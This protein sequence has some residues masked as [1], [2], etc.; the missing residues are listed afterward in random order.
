LENPI[1]VVFMGLFMTAW[2][3]L[4]LR[5]KEDHGSNAKHEVASKKFRS[6]VLKM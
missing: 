6:E 3:H 1:A 2:L 5:G 4:V